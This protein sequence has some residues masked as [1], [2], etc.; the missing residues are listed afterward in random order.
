MTY[1]VLD[2][3]DLKHSLG[4]CMFEMRNFQEVLATDDSNFEDGGIGW[5]LPLLEV[6]DKQGSSDLRDRV[7]QKLEDMLPAMEDL[8]T[9]LS[10]ISIK[11]TD[12]MKAIYP[13]VDTSRGAP[14]GR[15]D[16]NPD[17]NPE[18]DKLLRERVPLLEGYDLGGAYWGMNTRN[19]ALMV[20]Y[21]PD[22]SYIR[23]FRGKP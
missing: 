22:Y 7:M 13:Q 19:N 8:H 15:L 10:S 16:V 1:R 4:N 21:L 6:L 20:E 3:D 17:S 11:A 5:G 23:F 14:M 9:L 2:T 12:H 18:E